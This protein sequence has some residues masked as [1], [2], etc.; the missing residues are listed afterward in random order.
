ML[1]RLVWQLLVVKTASVLI[2]F[3]SSKLRNRLD[4]RV[5]EDTST[6]AFYIQER[7]ARRQAEYTKAIARLYFDI[8][9][10]AP[11]NKKGR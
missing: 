9:R 2:L 5:S 11:Q 8:R 10:K 3:P 7:K 1:D 4:I 6:L